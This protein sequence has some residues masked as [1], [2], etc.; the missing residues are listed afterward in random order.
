MVKRLLISFLTI[1]VWCKSNAQSITS[2]SPLC[3]DSKPTLQLKPRVGQ[4]ING[5]VLTIF[6]PTTK[7]LP[8]PMPVISTQVKISV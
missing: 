8:L 2:N 5:R 1:S 3:V 6:S 7:S 4:P